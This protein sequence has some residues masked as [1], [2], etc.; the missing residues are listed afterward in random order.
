M[1]ISQ[2]LN[3][4]NMNFSKGAMRP[5]RYS[6]KMF[7]NINA[8]GIE[9]ELF[10]PDY[11]HKE[12]KYPDYV[13]DKAYERALELMVSE[14]YD[15]D[16]YHEMIVGDRYDDYELES[17]FDG[18]EE[19]YTEY[20]I[21]RYFHDGDYEQYLESEHR[22][23]ILNRIDDILYDYTGEMEYDVDEETHIHN[24]YK[25]NAFS[26]LSKLGW[27]VEID[28][29]VPYEEYGYEIQSPKIFN[30]KELI[31]HLR[32]LER[33][34]DNVDYEFDSR[35]GLHVHVSFKDRPDDIVTFNVLKNTNESDVYKYFPNREN[36][37]Y[38][39][40]I[41][42][43]INYDDKELIELFNSHKSN[44]YKLLMKAM[45]GPDKTI[46]IHKPF[47]HYGINMK[48]AYPTYE[49]RYGTLNG[50]IKSNEIIDT[51][52][53]WCL[54]IS[55]VIN[56]SFA[57]KE[58]QSKSGNVII[59]KK[60]NFYELIVNGKVVN[61]SKDIGF[62]QAS[63]RLS[64]ETN[65]TFNLA[66][67]YGKM[68]PHNSSLINIIRY[69]NLNRSKVKR[70]IVVD[71]IDAVMKRRK[72]TT[73]KQITEFAL[74]I[75]KSRADA[76]LTI[77]DGLFKSIIMYFEQKG[78]S[79]SGY[80]LAEVIRPDMYKLIKNSSS[81]VRNELACYIFAITI[82]IKSTRPFVVNYVNSRMEESNFRRKLLT[83]LSKP[84]MTTV[85]DVIRVKGELLASLK[86][87]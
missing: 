8:F 60:N 62:D 51:I 55:Q 47:K 2:L 67:D 45:D 19:R 59:T 32:T 77:S 74:A 68:Y 75:M 13:Y 85:E 48:T 79:Y 53:R 82:T 41:K 20:L 33:F 58:I 16:G 70:K 42:D 71:F 52:N 3:E 84:V 66:N 27:T 1:K 17:D 56:E 37:G 30:K 28:G 25:S 73:A 61:R 44:K 21:D 36:T 11:Y 34:L 40:T 31:E 78:L 18:D 39:N 43:F 35:T 6:G 7:D 64:K 9:I 23:E 4:V 81:A 57:S 87:E 49:F 80:N 65:Y 12:E 26:E 83:V 10:L 50:M 38:A 46:I 14:Q 54:Y 76:T 22:D 15:I 29:S 86:N 63:Y 5:D 72:T 24:L 69:I